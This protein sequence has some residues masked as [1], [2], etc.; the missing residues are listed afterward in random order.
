M[1]SNRFYDE[2]EAEEILKRASS[3]P[4]SFGAV[5]HGRLLSMAAELGISP[6]AVERAEREMVRGQTSD[7]YQQQEA[8]WRQ[9][10]EAKEKA[11]IKQGW[12]SWLVVNFFL[13]II[14]FFT[15]KSGH[16]SEPITNAFGALFSNG[17]AWPIWVAAMWGGG[18]LIGNV[19]QA[20][21]RE[22]RWDRYKRTKMRKSLDAMNAPELQGKLEQIY[23]RKPTRDEAIMLL[24]SQTR[25]SLPD[26][27]AVVIEYERERGLSGLK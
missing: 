13:L 12:S 23:R 5:D 6:E 15:W 20:S 10:F 25:L 7:L 1:A 26:A 18:N 9:Q 22:Q 19:S 14:W 27:L 16:S 11:S 8:E 3:D 21:N 24:R 17:I 2:N 4:G